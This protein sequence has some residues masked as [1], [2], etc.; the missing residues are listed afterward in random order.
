M[1]VLFDSWLLYA[2]LAAIFAALTTICED[3]GPERQL[4][5]RDCDPD[6]HYSDFYCGD[7]GRARAHLRCFFSDKKDDAVSGVVRACDRPVVA[8]LFQGTAIR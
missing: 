1:K 2:V 6:R 8:E 7:R 4:E 3:R 5:C